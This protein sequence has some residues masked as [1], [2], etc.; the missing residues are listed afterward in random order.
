[1]FYPIHI[2]CRK[3][4]RLGCAWIAGTIGI[5][6]SSATLLNKRELLS[7]NIEKA[8]DE[9]IS[10]NEPMA[11]RLSAI[12][13]LGITRI[14]KR[15]TKFLLVDIE[16]MY[17]D[18]KKHRTVSIDLICSNNNRGAN[19]ALT[20]YVGDTEIF[21]TDHLL[22]D[23][24]T[25]LNLISDS[26]YAAYKTPAVDS[27]QSII[28]G[29]SNDSF[30]KME[31]LPNFTSIHSMISLDGNS[32]SFNQQFNDNFDPF[33]TSLANNFSL[34]LPP[35]DSMIHPEVEVNTVE[36]SPTNMDVTG[37]PMD[38]SH[39]NLVRTALNQCAL[40]PIQEEQ[41]RPPK[42]RKKHDKL[43][44]DRNTC[45]TNDQIRKGLATEKDTL[46]DLESM[47]PRRG[48][49]RYR[50]PKSDSELMGHAHFW[51]MFP[52]PNWE[53]LEIMKINVLQKSTNETVSSTNF[54]RLIESSNS[55]LGESILR[56]IS[57]VSVN[58]LQPADSIIEN[59]DITPMHIPQDESLII[60][61][62]PNISCPSPPHSDFFL[63]D[64]MSFR[65]R[66][67]F[68]SFEVRNHLSESDDILERFHRLEQ[69][70]KRPFIFMKD[71]FNS[72]H[73]KR[74]EV[75][76]VFYS[77]LKHAPIFH[78]EQAEPYG[79]ILLRSY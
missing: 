44:V 43:L 64:D 34:S 37:N 59:A 50:L 26:S 35:D 25:N 2:L 78:P 57:N 30:A 60:P 75:A 47:L 1:M 31:N 18:L 62:D 67:D 48:I 55:Q 74:K 61:T 16:D 14:Y 63:E 51:Q 71:L 4:G 33:E 41:E 7:V 56:N 45:L 20:N 52:N 70:T 28:R 9:V 72:K 76:S 3:R 53:E 77:I 66:E 27:F 17:K 36:I 13:M 40:D 39:R 15:Q 38:S 49:K 6:Q 58:G 32:G 73:P 29:G 79:E 8:C 5:N 10:P 21:E 23:L 11:L 65:R 19:L 24:L 42:R 22:M 12:L 46:R 68:D 54:S 69:S